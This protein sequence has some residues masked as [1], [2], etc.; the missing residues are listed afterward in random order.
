MYDSAKHAAFCVPKPVTSDALAL[1]ETVTSPNM[2]TVTY[3]AFLL[4]L[5]NVAIAFL[6]VGTS[7]HA[8]DVASEAVTSPIYA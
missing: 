1:T 7:F 3:P 5:Y 6:C 2:S 4:L 8:G